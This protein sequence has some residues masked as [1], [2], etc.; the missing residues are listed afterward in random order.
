MELINSKTAERGQDKRGDMR[1]FQTS[2]DDRQSAHRIVKQQLKKYFASQWPPGTRL[3]PLKKLATQLGAGHRSLLRAIDELR[4]EGWAQSAPRR[5]TTVCDPAKMRRRP[6]AVPYGVAGKTAAILVTQP[7]ADGFALSIAQP[8][9][10]GLAQAGM[11]AR[12]ELVKFAHEL[13]V[14][15]VSSHGGDAVCVI[16]PSS[17]AWIQFAS[18]QALLVISTSPENKVQA[19]GGFDIVSVDH[20]QGATIAGW[21]LREIGCRRIGYLGRGSVTEGVTQFDA[22][23]AARLHGLEQGLGEPVR[24]DWQMT[25]RYYD[26]DSAAAAVRDYLKLSPR[27][28]GIFAASDEIAIGFVAGAAAHGLTAGKDYQ[29][30]GFDGQPAG[31]RIVCGP[32]STIDVQPQRL[33]SAGARMLIER[34]SNPDTPSRRIQL[35]GILRTGNTARPQEAVDTFGA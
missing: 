29:I 6:T 21:R 33:G 13:T 12:I 8:L 11:S 26:Y 16:N 30:I 22:I 34:L 18:T 19:S 10:E 32:L 14:N 9:Q 3:P 23:S 2:S 28:D 24:T 7:V 4:D 15:D 1:K 20:T 25:C 5:G 35:G 17:H 27:P 31:D